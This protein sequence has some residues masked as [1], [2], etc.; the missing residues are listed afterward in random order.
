MQEEVTSQVFTSPGDT[1]SD[2]IATIFGQEFYKIFP[3][4]ILR[5]DYTDGDLDKERRSSYVL[6]NTR[7]P[8][9]LTENFFMDNYEEY[10]DILM[11][12]E[13]RD[14]IAQYHINT[15]LRVKTEVF[16]EAPAVKI[17]TH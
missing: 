10:R 16:N 7:M 15:I 8:A 6:T 3:D 1:L 13:G 9:I 17:N 12:K 11:T 5:T 4:R 2:T 14:R